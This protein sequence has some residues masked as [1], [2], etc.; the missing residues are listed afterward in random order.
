MVCGQGRG[1]FNC[2]VLKTRKDDTVQTLLDIFLKTKEILCKYDYYIYIQK[3]VLHL[4]NTEL[5]VPHLMGMQYIG[6]PNQ[7]TG[8]NGV[9]AIKKKRITI[10]SIE[11][12][13]RKYY[14]KE[15]QQQVMMEM[16][17]RKLDN[18]YLLE[19]MFHS[20][21][22]L[23]LYE[24]TGGVQT[25]FDCDYLMV[26]ESGKAVLHLGLI[27]S[28]T[29]KGMYHCN[30]FMTTYQSDRERDIFFCNLSRQ[31]EISK[32]IRED[33]QSKERETV[34]LSEQAELRE[35]TGITKMFA[36]AGMEM[37]DE[38]LK[39]ILRLNVKF[40]EYHTLDML[41]DTGQLKKKCRNK[42]EEALVGDFIELWE[43][44]FRRKIKDGI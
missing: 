41:S 26:H 22:K 14:K 33:K 8:D 13:V 40:G 19:E 34:Y 18:L 42:R 35:R 15:K 32:I 9:Y 24:K 43:K 3:Q 36:A 6:R 38:L 11:K 28:S 1:Y 39:M 23:Y 2:P 10:N 16:I 4:T 21:S 30:S 37:D 31:Y 27:K 29:R 25:G 12:L 17:Y 20:Y 7:F 44:K 5:K